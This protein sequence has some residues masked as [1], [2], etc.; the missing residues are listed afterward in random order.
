MNIL[1]RF[2]ALSYRNI[3]IANCYV[4]PVAIGITDV[5]GSKFDGDFIGLK[6][7]ESPL[8]LI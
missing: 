1:E 4:I 8:T 7:S 5:F 6:E 3:D 2:H